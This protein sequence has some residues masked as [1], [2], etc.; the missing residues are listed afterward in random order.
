MLTELIHHLS[1]FFGRGRFGDDLAD[2]ARFHI[3]TRADEL[4]TGGMS[5]KAAIAEAR[6]EFGS[7]SLMQEDVRAAW[8]FQWVEGLLSD[9]RYAPR[10]VRR[11]PGF[12]VTRSCAWRSASARRPLPRYFLPPEIPPG[13]GIAAVIS[14]SPS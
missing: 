9:L 14:R 2:E 13:T 7:A 3:E 11:S 4:A 5:P 6:R 10:G 8:R 1:H 12:A